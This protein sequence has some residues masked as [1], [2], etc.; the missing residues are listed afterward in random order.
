M[1]AISKALN[2]VHYYYPSSSQALWHSLMRGTTSSHI[3]L[4]GSTQATRLPPGMVNLFGMHNIPPLTLTAG[5]HFTYP[6]RDGGRWRNYFCS[7]LVYH[8]TIQQ[9]IHINPFLVTRKLI[10]E[11]IQLNLIVVCK[12]IHSSYTKIQVIRMTCKCT[13]FNI[14]IHTYS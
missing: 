11:G 8:L 14:L 9:H 2:N 4:L 1:Y 7:F 3:N 13:K 12:G 6:H 10:T 5:T